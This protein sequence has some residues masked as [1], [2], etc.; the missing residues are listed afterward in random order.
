MRSVEVII[1]VPGTHSLFPLSTAVQASSLGLWY[2]PF[3]DI[4]HMRREWTS[5]M[6]LHQVLNGSRKHGWSTLV[7]NACVLSRSWL[8]EELLLSCYIHI[9]KLCFCQVQDWCLWC[10]Q[11]VLLQCLS[12]HS[13]PFCSSS[14]CSIWDSVPRSVCLCT[15]VCNDI[16]KSNRIGSVTDRFKNKWKKFSHCVFQLLIGIAHCPL[17]AVF[18]DGMR[19]GFSDWWIRLRRPQ[20]SH[21][22]LR[23]PIFH[24]RNLLCLWAAFCHKRRFFCFFLAT[25]YR[26]LWCFYN[27]AKFENLNKDKGEAQTHLD[28]R[29]WFCQRPQSCGRVQLPA[30]E[31]NEVRCQSRLQP[32]N[33][34]PLWPKSFPSTWR[35]WHT[36]CLCR[37]DSTLWTW[38]TRMLVVS[39]CYSLDCLN[40]WCCSMFTVCL[41]YIFWNIFVVTWFHIWSAIF[42]TGRKSDLSTLCKSHQ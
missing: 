16:K 32:S 11:K 17:I 5:R 12:L 28:Q 19:L 20:K 6:S 37:E 40:A 9:R 39:L 31:W 29:G 30:G 35:N 8:Q 22:N 41:R 3:W 38:W 33:A 34:G 18:H 1:I 10:I 25:F 23:F 15:C 36:T 4:W 2:S 27:V 7:E 21:P 26:V 24:V 14:W 13:G 42:T